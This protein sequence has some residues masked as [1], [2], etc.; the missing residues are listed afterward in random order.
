[1]YFCNKDIWKWFGLTSLEGMLS[2]WSWVLNN[3]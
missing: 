3:C 1:V 2:F